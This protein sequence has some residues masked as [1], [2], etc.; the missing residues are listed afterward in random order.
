VREYRADELA[1]LLK[2]VFDS[3][4]IRGLF[5]TEELYRIEFERC[6]KAL[7]TARTGDSPRRQ[8]LIEQTRDAIAHLAKVLLPSR[9]VEYIRVRRAVTIPELEPAIIEKYSTRDF[10]YCSDNPDE[11][12]DLLAICTVT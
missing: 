7:R 1:D 2:T 5:A 8:S 11:A 6:Q 4:E 12:L 10:F 3:V 9:V